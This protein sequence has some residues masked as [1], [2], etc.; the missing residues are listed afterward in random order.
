[1]TASPFDPHLVHIL[2]R[3]IFRQNFRSRFAPRETIKCFSFC[4]NLSRLHSSIQNASNKLNSAHRSYVKSIMYTVTGR[5]IIKI[6]CCLI[7]RAA[8]N[9]FIEKSNGHF[10]WDTHIL[11]IQA[12][13]N[14]FTFNHM[15][16]TNRIEIDWTKSR[17]YH[18]FLPWHSVHLSHALSFD[19]L[20]LQYS[21]IVSHRERIPKN[22]E[23]SFS[24]FLLNYDVNIL[25]VWS[26]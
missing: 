17:R 5:A 13:F 1:M 22:A 12:T 15:F 26:N 10:H 14:W 23:F 18:F 8:P 19:L 2:D 25:I 24:V 11:S 6:S 16:S 20:I 4:F 9:V 7:C 21:R 3:F